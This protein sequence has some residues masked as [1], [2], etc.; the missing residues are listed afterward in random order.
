MANNR[1]LRV[2]KDLNLRHPGENLALE[3]SIVDYVNRNWSPPTLRFWRNK[4]SAII[5]RS[6]RAAD[7]VNMPA[8]NENG[9][10][11]ARRPSGGGAVIHHPKN[12]NYSIYLSSTQDD[13][14]AENADR[15]LEP[16][17]KSLKEGGI[18]TR[19]QSNGLFVDDLKISGVAQSRRNGLLFHGTLLL[20]DNELMNK[21]DQVL[22]AHN[23]NYDHDSIY[24]PSKP[25]P[26]GCVN[27]IAEHNFSFSR[28]LDRWTDYLSQVLNLTPVNG[29]I[30]QFE[31]KR[32]EE[33]AENK[34]KAHE[35]NFRFDR[36]GKR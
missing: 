26:V 10:I 15:F 29:P 33:L 18:K 31:W 34:Y 19:S 32:A 35:W 6:Q 23:R 11:V 22:L 28:F 30:S 12:L 9:I 13:G 2:I 8:C 1:T 17:I 21:M 3:E 25:S 36:E 27:E 5:G 14:I 24:V 16:L 4:Y 7:E 20:G